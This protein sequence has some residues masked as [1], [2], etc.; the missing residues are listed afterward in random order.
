[1]SKKISYTFCKDVTEAILNGAQVVYKKTTP[2][3]HE[4]GKV[5]LITILLR[6]PKDSFY[7]Y[8]DG[9]KF[10]YA[11]AQN[12]FKRGEIMLAGY[13]NGTLRGVKK[14]VS[15]EHMSDCRD[16]YRIFQNKKS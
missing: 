10:E 2:I 12:F 13:K 9:R 5:E 15:E 8:E 3:P 4:D 14:R 16:Q 6:F 1:M 11:W 7:D